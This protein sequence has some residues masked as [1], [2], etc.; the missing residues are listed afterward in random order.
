M[1][2]IICDNYVYDKHTFE[3]LVSPMFTDINKLEEM[4][5]YLDNAEKIIAKENGDDYIVRSDL[6]EVYSVL[7]LPVNNNHH[8][9]VMIKNNEKFIYE[10]V[11][12]RK[13]PNENLDNKRKRIN[14]ILKN[15]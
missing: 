10:S 4:H 3:D 11:M 7:G 5:Q 6:S 13:L 12:V 2:V 15:I 9:V 14:V 1:K 8:R